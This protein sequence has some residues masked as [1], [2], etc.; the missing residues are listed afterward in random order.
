MNNGKD[1]IFTMETVPLKVGIGATEEVGADLKGM[2]VKKVLLVTDANLVKLGLPEKVC[3]YIIEARVDVDIYDRVHIEP[4]DESWLEAIEFTKAKGY[5][6]FVALG[7]GSSIDTAKAINLLTTYPADIMDYVNKP[8]GKA[9]PVP[10]PLRPM[11]AIPTTAGTGSETTSVCAFEIVSLKVKTGISHRRLRPSLGI[12]DPLNTLSLPPAVTV[13]SGIDVLTHALESYLC[14]PY[15]E[16]IRPSTPADRP[17]YIGSNPISDI[18]SRRAIELV[19]MYLPRAVQ[20]GNDLEARFQMAL[21]STF[22]GMGFGNAG[23][24]IP[25][26]MAYP[27]AGLVRNYIPPGYP[28]GHPMVPHGISVIVGAPAA[29]RFTASVLPEKHLQAAQL[30]GADISNVAPPEGGYLLAKTLIA[31]MREL[32]LPNGVGE[33]GYTEADIPELAE[34]AMKQ[35]RLLTLSPRPV[36]QEDLE[37]IFADAMQYW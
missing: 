28:D 30:I 4:T 17:S 15:N 6:G 2:G 26:A 24:H 10:G 36:T 22:A 13:S 11:I 34:G 7:G 5:N 8:I 18:W 19:R 35:Q 1:P 23:T 9:K 14:K 27:I 25:H 31:L 12:I 3:G 20:N 21:A 16:R 33:L 37:R 32:G 29:F